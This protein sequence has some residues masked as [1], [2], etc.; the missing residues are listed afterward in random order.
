MTKQRLADLKTEFEM[1]QQIVRDL[2][3]EWKERGKESKRCSDKYSSLLIEHLSVQGVD[4]QDDND[5]DLLLVAEAVTTA[6]ALLVDA[7]QAEGKAFSSYTRAVSRSNA[8]RATLRAVEY[9]AGREASRG[10]SRSPTSRRCPTI[11]RRSS[12]SRSG[13]R[14]GGGS[15]SR[16]VNKRPKHAPRGF[17]L[18]VSM[19]LG[20]VGQGLD[21]TRF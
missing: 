21:S 7:K 3:A 12:P 13:E 15:S 10:P 6:R 2:E 20:W 14:E 5:V 16:I 18:L 1:T 11:A 8:L 19:H 4:A 17:G 9:L